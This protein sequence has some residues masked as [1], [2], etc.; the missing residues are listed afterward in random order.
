MSQISFFCG[1]HAECDVF[2]SQQ[3]FKRA[4]DNFE[5]WFVVTGVLEYMKFSIKVME[6]F[7]PRYFQGMQPQFF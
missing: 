3:M 5:R 4:L 6:K 2:E 1:H 7:I